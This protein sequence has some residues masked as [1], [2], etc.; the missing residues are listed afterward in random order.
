M[1]GCWLSP[2]GIDK[3]P[4]R[5]THRVGPRAIPMALARP[6]LNADYGT[7]GVSK[8]MRSPAR[9]TAVWPRTRHRANGNSVRF[10]KGCMKARCARSIF[11]RTARPAHGHHSCGHRPAARP[12]EPEH[13]CTSA[14]SLQPDDGSAQKP[15]VGTSVSKPV[16]SL[17]AAAPV[18]PG[19]GLSLAHDLRESG[20]SSPPV[21]VAGG[22]RQF[23]LCGCS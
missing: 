21:A 17:F 13:L 4:D 11:K 8:V 5:V 9:T 16:L 19:I 18:Y 2:S 20:F 23:P 14:A 10:S 7:R 1:A 22:R 15:P 6:V 12:V 3:I